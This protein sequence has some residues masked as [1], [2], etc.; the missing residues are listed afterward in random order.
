MFFYQGFVFR[1]LPGWPGSGVASA[2]GATAPLRRQQRLWGCPVNL[3]W[4]SKIQIKL[5]GHSHKGFARCHLWGE[6]DP[7]ISGW[8]PPPTPVLDSTVFNVSMAGGSQGLAPSARPPGYADRNITIFRCRGTTEQGAPAC[9]PCW[10]LSVVPHREESNLAPLAPRWDWPSSHEPCIARP[11]G[12]RD[13]Y[14][15]LFCL[16]CTRPTP[17]K[18]PADGDF[19]CLVGALGEQTED[20]H[21]I[22]SPMLR[23]PWLWRS[24]GR[25]KMLCLSCPLR[26]SDSASPKWGAERDDQKLKVPMI[27]TKHHSCPWGRRGEMPAKFFAGIFL[28]L[29]SHR[30]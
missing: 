27:T 1:T 18:P 14:S 17:S 3:I 2:A 25:L 9:A 8:S 10:S 15:P 16:G 29:F 6:G 4:F 28:P 21:G 23:G 7:A 13:A 11:A 12:Q 24:G 20:K 5:T 22:H 30:L 19:C 26:A